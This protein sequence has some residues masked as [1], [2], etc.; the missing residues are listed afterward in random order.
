MLNACFSV[1]QWPSTMVANIKRVLFSWTGIELLLY[2]LLKILQWAC[3]LFS[4]CCREAYI[5]KH[6]QR[7]LFHF[8]STTIKSNGPPLSASCTLSL[9]CTLSSVPLWQQWD[10]EFQGAFSIFSHARR[11]VLHTNILHGVPVWE[12]YYTLSSIPAR[13]IIYHILVLV[14]NN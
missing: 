3:P 12:H 7:N 6:F 11:I 10:E 8:I 4:V 9:G 5:E 13:N 2:A 1:L 14:F